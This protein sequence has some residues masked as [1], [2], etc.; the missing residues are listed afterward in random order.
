MQMTH[1]F[2]R[3][4]ASA[5]EYKTLIHFSYTIIITTNENIVTIDNREF[6]Q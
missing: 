2:R 1:V 5:S 3:K 6:L 4:T